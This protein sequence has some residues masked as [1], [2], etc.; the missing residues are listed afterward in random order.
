MNVTRVIVGHNEKEEKRGW[1]LRQVRVRVGDSEGDFAGSYWTFPCDRF[2]LCC[3][4]LIGVTLVSAAS[5]VYRIMH[6]I[7]LVSFEVK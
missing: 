7:L 6:V 4:L 5:S 2:V 1:F 3:I